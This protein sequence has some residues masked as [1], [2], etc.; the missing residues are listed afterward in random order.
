MFYEMKES[1]HFTD[2]LNQSL[3]KELIDYE[4]H[5]SQTF[6]ARKR[7]IARYVERIEREIHKLESGGDAGKLNAAAGQKDYKIQLEQKPKK[8]PLRC[9]QC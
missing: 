2:I 9:L 5:V 7:D 8:Y 1:K 4:R 6:A 3:K